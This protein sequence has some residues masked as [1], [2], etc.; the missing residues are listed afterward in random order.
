MEYT[1]K[2]NPQKKSYAELGFTGLAAR[3][4]ATMNHTSVAV[5][6]TNFGLIVSTH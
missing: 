5:C 1:L 6:A 3:G 4:R 2:A